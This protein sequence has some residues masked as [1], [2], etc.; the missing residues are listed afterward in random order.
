MYYLLCKVLV[1]ALVDYGWFNLRV[2]VVVMFLVEP[3]LLAFSKQSNVY[4]IHTVN[5]LGE[6]FMISTACSH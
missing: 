3:N 4:V 6:S 5:N 1:R 2:K